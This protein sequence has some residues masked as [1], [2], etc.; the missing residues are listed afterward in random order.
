[1]AGTSRVEDPQNQDFGPRNVHILMQRTDTKFTHWQK[2]PIN[3]ELPLLLIRRGQD[4]S[5]I[6]REN[7]CNSRAH[8]QMRRR[9]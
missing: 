8:Q 4:S 2:R 6:Y 1:M 3:I 7:Q 5:A 9:K